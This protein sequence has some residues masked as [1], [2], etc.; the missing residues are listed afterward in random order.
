MSSISA[1]EQKHGNNATAVVEQLG[2]LNAA[3][4]AKFGFIFM[5]FVNG[6]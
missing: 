5:E 3:Y 2:V 1:S 4:E 6:R